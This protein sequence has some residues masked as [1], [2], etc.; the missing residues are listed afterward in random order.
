MMEILLLRG[1]RA[2]ERVFS[3]CSARAIARAQNHL[4]LAPHPLLRPWVAHYTFTFPSGPPEDGTLAL[5][6]DASGCILLSLD[7]EARALAWGATTTIRAFWIFQSLRKN[8]GN[9]NISESPEVISFTSLANLSSTERTTEN[10]WGVP[11]ILGR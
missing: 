10:I 4:Y 8:A 3:L 2:M 1:G 11:F 6:P 9:G 5:I 7:G